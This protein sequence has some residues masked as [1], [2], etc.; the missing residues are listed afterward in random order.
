LL[1]IWS[2]VLSSIDRIQ[3]CLQSIQTTFYQA[4]N[5]LGTLNDLTVNWK[6]RLCARTI[7]DVEDLCNEWGVI[8]GELR[9]YVPCLVEMHLMLNWILGKKCTVV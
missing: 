6:I 1:F 5:Q 3:K 8:V 2:E 9:R 4:L 7:C